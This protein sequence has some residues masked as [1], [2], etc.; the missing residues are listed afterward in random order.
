MLLRDLEMSTQLT[1]EDLENRPFWFE[2]AAQGTR[3]LS[4]VL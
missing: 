4:P 1:R 3:L 2:L